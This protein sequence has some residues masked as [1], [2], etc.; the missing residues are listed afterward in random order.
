MSKI[1]KVWTVHRDNDEY[2]NGR[3]TDVCSGEDI[4]KIVACRSGWYGG[5]APIQENWAVEI[6]GD[7]YLL[8]SK[9]PVDLDGKLT[10][11]KKELKAHALSKLSPEEIAALGIKE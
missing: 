4:A 8:A 6:D 2:K 1:F 10:K 11:A 7:I 3:I 9:D 5:N